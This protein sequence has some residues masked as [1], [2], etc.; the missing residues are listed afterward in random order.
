[1]KTTSWLI[2]LTAVHLQISGLAQAAGDYVAHEWGTFTSVQ[3][4]DGIQLAWNPLNV[5]ELPKFVYDVARTNNGIATNAIAERFSSK[6]L[7]MTLQRMETPVIYL[8]SD[9]EQKVNVSVKFPQ[10]LITEWYPRIAPWKPRGASIGVGPN[11]LEWKDLQVLPRNRHPQLA[12]ELPVESSGSHYY[13][14]RETDADFV[15]TSGADALASNETEKFLFYRGVG[16]F[17]APLTVTQSGDD[18]DVLTMQNSGRD[19]LRHLFV[20][21]VRGGQAK[22]VFVPELPGGTNR[23]VTLKPAEDLGPLSDV[24]ARLAAELE[25]ALVSEGLYGAEA[26]AMVKTWDDSW[27]AEQ[28]VRVLYTLPRAWTDRILPLTL[29]PK[30]REVVRVMVGRAELITPSMEWALL[31]QI[32]HYSEADALTRNQIVAETQKLGLGRFLQPAASRLTSSFRHPQFAQS[33][34]DLVQLAQKQASTGK[35]LAVK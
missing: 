12:Q 33:S 3:G 11:Q 30:P 27:F 15:Q 1:M 18:A 5:A 8:Y 19:E 7:F 35:S 16:S 29:D 20:Y 14:A 17:A 32:V 34:A 24:R 22:F 31:K 25:E 4:A 26:K 28:G 10:G 6:S 13:S 2:V 9:R 23:V 21:A